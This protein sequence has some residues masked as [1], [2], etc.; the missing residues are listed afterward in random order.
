[1]SSM[2]ERA[3]VKVTD[4]AGLDAV[5]LAAARSVAEAFQSSIRP[6]GAVQSAMRGSGAQSRRR[7]SFSSEARHR[8]ELARA[9]QRVRGVG[10]VQ[11]VDGR[12]SRRL[13]GTRARRPRSLE[14]T[15]LAVAEAVVAEGEHAPGDRDLGDLAATTLGDA[16]EGGAQ[17]AATGCCF[18]RCFDQGPADVRRALP[19]DVTKP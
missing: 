1:M 9:V 3:C 17:R 2:K 5:P 13:D 8:S 15:D 19:G 11:V 7:P 12:S 6:R 16:F 14:A 4:F 10:R 18:L